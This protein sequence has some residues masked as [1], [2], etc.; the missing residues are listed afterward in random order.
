MLVDGEEA[1]LLAPLADAEAALRFAA[2][3]LQRASR[4]RHAQLHAHS[5]PALFWAHP[6]VGEALLAQPPAHWQQ[7]AAPW[8]RQRL[9]WGDA[10]L[11]DAALSP[12]YAALCTLDLTTAQARLDW[13]LGTGLS[14]SQAAAT[15]APPGL[16]LLSKPP[17]QHAALAARVDELAG[18]WGVG[19]RLAAAL[20][21]V[22]PAMGAGAA[23]T[24]GRL[25]GMLQVRGLL[26]GAAGV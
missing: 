6:E 26:G 22:Q 21:L 12:Q 25:V 8:L 16:R 10:A 23:E 9:G 19:R 11:A 15:L 20:V 24:T 3:Q 7:H 17:A 5:L 4:R 18:A 1:A 14:P 2:A 13:L